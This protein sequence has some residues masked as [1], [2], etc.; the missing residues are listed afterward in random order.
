[1]F[2]YT[3]SKLDVSVGNTLLK[4]ATYPRKFQEQTIYLSHE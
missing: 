1:M 4:E 2:S 3:F